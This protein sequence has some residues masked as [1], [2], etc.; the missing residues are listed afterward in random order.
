MQV[1]ETDA[2]LVNKTKAGN[3]FLPNMGTFL[4]LVRGSP[5]SSGSARL[6]DTSVSNSV[7]NL[8]FVDLAA[9]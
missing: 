7:Q 2:V 8:L 4:K 1:S 5:E 3:F 6:K 9:C